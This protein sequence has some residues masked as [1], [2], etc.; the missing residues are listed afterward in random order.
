MSET[1]T[2]YTQEQINQYAEM[3]NLIPNNFAMIANM[4]RLEEMIQ[5]LAHNTPVHHNPEIDTR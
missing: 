1:N 2:K 4:M 3:Y 5:E